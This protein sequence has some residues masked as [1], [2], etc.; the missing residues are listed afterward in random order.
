[1][2][3][4][5]N[6]RSREVVL[7]RQEQRNGRKTNMITSARRT[8]E[9]ILRIQQE[10]MNRGRVGRIT[11]PPAPVHYAAP[12]PDNSRITCITP[13]G[14]RPLAFALCRQWMKHQTVK[15]TQWIV[16]D[17]GKVPMVPTGSFQYVRREPR[18]DD[19]PFTLSPNLAA[20]LPL[21]KGDKVFII[22]DDEYYAPDYIA[23]MSKRLD[24]HEVVGLMHAKY[25]HLPTGGYKQIS[26]I[27][28]ANL[29]ET[30]FRGSFLPEMPEIVQ[31]SNDS[32]VDLRIWIKAG[33]RGYRFS[34]NEKSLYLGI[35]GLPGRNGIGV[36]HNPAIYRNHRDTTDR[37]ML[38]KW[39]PGDYQIYLDI[40]SGKLTSENYQS[41]FPS[42]LPITGIT[43]CQ[44]T[45]ELVERSYNSI[46]KFHPEIPIIIIDG[47][48]VNDP[49]AAYVRGLASDVT[50]VVSLGY[51]IGH[52]RGMCMGIEKAK[53]PYALMFDSDIE[54][55]KPCLPE[56]LAMMEEDTFG[57]GDID[58]K[59]NLNPYVYGTH[60]PAEGFVRYLHPYFQLMNIENY[61]KY[62][63]YVHHGG[64]C[65]WTML[66]I[67]NQGLS[68]KI[69]KQFPAMK[70]FVKHDFMGTRK[71]RMAKKLPE[72][73]GK[74]EVR[75][76][77][78]CTS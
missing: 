78:K 56:M 47:S 21:V 26:N 64:P 41:Y 76:D 53:T 63:P 2:I 5:R 1:M 77:A 9:A 70:E 17:D 57:V 52:G 75:E 38:K 24:Q 58:E 71:T 74:W 46:R 12:M 35:K 18:A 59:S 73:E 51:N 15:P 23:E 65:C 68:G 42:D 50:I 19:P 33:V 72:I 49:C 4:H 28:H 36:G 27:T 20:A 48:N 54:M 45:R 40:L 13:T 34:D 7:R 6:I 31:A 69:L 44:N 32:Y 55:L 25:Y 14:D 39:I 11:S 62:Y 22:E 3:T 10:R 66:D 67:H 30:T 29:A 43:V 61:K 37:A 16:V 8:R 60:S